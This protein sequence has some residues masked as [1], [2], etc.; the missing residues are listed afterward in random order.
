[1]SNYPSRTQHVAAK[2]VERTGKTVLNDTK[3]IIEASTGVQ[4]HPGTTSRLP[5]QPSE[6]KDAVGQRIIEFYPCY[7]PIG[8]VTV[9]VERYDGEPALWRD[10]TMDEARAI[11]L[12]L[13]NVLEE[14]DKA[15]EREP[16]DV[17][18]AKASV[19][20][21]DKPSWKSSGGREY[22]PIKWAVD[23]FDPERDDAE[24]EGQTPV[25]NNKVDEPVVWF[26]DP[27][28]AHEIV[29]RLNERNSY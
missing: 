28:T 11:A 17:T 25:T 1:M 29:T 23:V 22:V 26:K 2:T 14:V 19:G 13:V 16:K 5:Y 6:D 24:R 7:A 18:D 21:T 20:A 10:M 27:D 12:D 8:G 3:A 15:E 4:R 9:R